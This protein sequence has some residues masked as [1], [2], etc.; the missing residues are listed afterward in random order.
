M[1][2]A[3]VYFILWVGPVGQ[4]KAAIDLLKYTVLL[5]TSTQGPREEQP[6]RTVS[7]LGMA[8]TCSLASTARHGLCSGQR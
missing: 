6:A 4:K 5:L 2:K 3:R 8:I 7:G 1:S